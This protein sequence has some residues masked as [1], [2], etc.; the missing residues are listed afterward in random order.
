M[1]HLQYQEPARIGGWIA[2]GASAAGRAKAAG[3]KALAAKALA[4]AT[5]DARGKGQGGKH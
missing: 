3:A 1:A 4:E 2:P 5:A